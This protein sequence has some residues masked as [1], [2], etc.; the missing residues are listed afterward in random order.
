MPKAAEELSCPAQES[1]HV[2]VLREPGPRVTVGNNTCLYFRTSQTTS[3]P[4]RKE[5]KSVF[6]RGW[7]GACFCCEEQQR[8]GRC[9]A[10]RVGYSWYLILNHTSWKMNS[11]FLSYINQNRITCIRRLVN[12]NKAK[13]S[14][15]VWKRDC[16]SNRLMKTIKEKQCKVH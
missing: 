3:Q 13:V 11:E 12:P 6:D 1:L 15:L 2:T 14:L 8:C 5:I 4:P 9:A 16:K 10:R 7:T